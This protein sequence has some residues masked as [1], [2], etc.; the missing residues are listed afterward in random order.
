VRAEELDVSAGTVY[1]GTPAQ[2]RLWASALAAADDLRGRLR[3]LQREG[4]GAT[5]ADVE[6]VRLALFVL[7]GSGQRRD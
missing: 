6:A 7:H 2:R 1:G 4:Y 3:V 5:S